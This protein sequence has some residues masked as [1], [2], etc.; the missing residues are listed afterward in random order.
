[1]AH[2]K[3]VTE[4]G[5]RTFPLGEAFRVGRSPDNDL[6]LS[7]DAAVS[8]QHALIR[9]AGSA[10]N[11]EDLGSQNGTFVVRGGSRIRATTL[12]ELQPGDLIEIGSARLLFELTVEQTTSATQVTD[13]HLTQVPERTR[14]GRVVPVGVPESKPRR[15]ED[16]SPW[17][18]IV[19]VTAALTA[20]ILAIVLALLLPSVL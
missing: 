3:Y 18:V 10:Y 9:Q 14:I 7:D 12:L 4:A 1:M 6:S 19:L 15:S 8:R 20:A 2:L 11:L 17:R 13:P 5:E 16:R